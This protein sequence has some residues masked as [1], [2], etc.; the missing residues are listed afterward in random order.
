MPGF[1][2]D[3]INLIAANLRDRYKS[4]FPI[5]KELIQN[6]D[7]AKAGTLVFGYHPG[8]PGNPLIPCCRGQHY[9]C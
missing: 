6:A 7:D 8:L 4:G 2:S 5:L 9:G 3:H 1:R